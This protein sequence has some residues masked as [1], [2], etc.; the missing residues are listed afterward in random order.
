[1][2]DFNPWFVHSSPRSYPLSA[3]LFGIPLWICLVAN[4]ALGEEVGKGLPS[5]SSFL[6][7]K[8]TRDKHGNIIRMPSTLEQTASP[9]AAEMET[10]KSVADVEPTTNGV[11]P[12]TIEKTNKHTENSALTVPRNVAIQQPVV[13]TKEPGPEATGEHQ[14]EE[15]SM[16]VQRDYGTEL[17]ASDPEPATLR[18]TARASTAPARRS[19]A[20]GGLREYLPKPGEW[21]LVPGTALRPYLVSCKERSISR[22]LLTQIKC[23]SAASAV[24]AWNGGAFDH[25]TQVLYLPAGGGH[26]D[27]G[28]NEIYTIDFNTRKA[29]RIGDPQ[30]LTGPDMVKG[31]PRPIQGPPAVHSY[32]GV[33]WVP[34]TGEIMLFGSVPYCRNAMVN[35]GET[36]SYQPRTGRWTALPDL[37]RFSRFARTAIAAN[38]DILVFTRSMLFQLDAHTKEVKRRSGKGPDLGDG[39]A[40]RDPKRNHFY[41]TQQRGLWMIDL[42]PEVLSEPLRIARL[43]PGMDQK[44]GMAYHPPSARLV[45]WDGGGRVVA[46]DPDSK[47]WLELTSGPRTPKNRGRGVYSRWFWLPE[48][49]AFAGFNNIDEG[50]WLY[51]PAMDSGRPPGAIDNHVRTQAVRPVPNKREKAKQEPSR[52]P[53]AI[54]PRIASTQSSSVGMSGAQRPQTFETRCAHPD[55]VLCDP[56]DTGRVRSV[57]LDA[58]T[59]CADGLPGRECKYRSWRWMRQA[60]KK[61]THPPKL[62]RKMKASGTG[63]LKF[64]IPTRSDANDSGYFQVNFTPD[65]SVQF[66]EGE[67]FFVQWRQRF[68]YEMLFD[69]TGARRK[70]QIL[71]GGKGGFKTVIINAGDHR[72]LNYPVDSCTLQHLVMINGGQKGVISMYHSCGWYA[73]LSTYHGL[74]ERGNG[75]FDSQ[76]GGVN[77]CWKYHPQTGD[78]LEKAWK[79]CELLQ[80]DEWMTFQV[81]VTV[82]K[83]ADSSKSSERSSN[84]KVWVAREGKPSRLVIDHKLNLRRPE[85]PFMKYGK[86]WLLPYHTKKD[87]SEDHPEAYTWYDELIVSRSR[88][89]DPK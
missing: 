21:Q 12:Q 65:N 8:L 3:A 19:S 55:V 72:K 23:E 25:S 79:D 11:K 84:I 14:V 75:Q 54:S 52:T 33:L 18:M 37:N 46:F 89:A 73:G 60:S 71:G 56:L 47:E 58:N 13:A 20:M 57:G 53:T 77:K 38:G 6:P 64:T 85:K 5:G 83:W 43:A 68:S 50:L 17:A 27:Y 24:Y 36:W 39:N 40:I 45:F 31:C 4:T 1:M 51:R 42:K 48:L 32:D 78:R 35:A 41:L 22:E 15:G 30:P 26:A 81:Q 88:I 76:P 86:V 2:K 59:P 80:P 67:T 7:G 63:S 70:Y 34:A 29:A 74:N 44:W 62:D 82:G 66:G 10:P 61:V 69:E 9:M 49:E 28:G 87:P 16:F